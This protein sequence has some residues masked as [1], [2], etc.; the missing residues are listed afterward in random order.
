V[1]NGCLEIYKSK[2]KMMGKLW[3]RNEQSHQTISEYIINN[4]SKWMEDKFYNRAAARDF[5]P[6]SI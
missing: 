2:N 5:C 3:Q 4:P 1:F 6:Y